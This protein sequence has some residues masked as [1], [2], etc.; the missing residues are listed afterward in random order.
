MMRKELELELSGT[1]TRSTNKS[2]R[3]SIPFTRKELQESLFI[4]HIVEVE[5]HNNPLIEEN[6]IESLSTQYT[7]KIDNSVLSSHSSITIPPSFLQVLE[8]LT[9]DLGENTENEI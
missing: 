9:P 2:E 6:E 4:E 5:I 7:E 8:N 3:E 1:R